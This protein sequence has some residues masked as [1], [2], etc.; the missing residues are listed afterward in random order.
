MWGGGVCQVAPLFDGFDLSVDCFDDDLPLPGPRSL[1]FARISGCTKQLVVL[2]CH[3]FHNDY[4]SALGYEC[5][6]ILLLARTSF[7]VFLDINR[8]LILLVLPSLF[9]PMW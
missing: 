9:W 5:F 2:F 1:S 4:G 7:R 8:A 3:V 6:N